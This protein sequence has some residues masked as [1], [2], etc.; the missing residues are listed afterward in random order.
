[1]MDLTENL[2]R[3]LAETVCGS[4]KIVYNGIEMDLSKPFERLTMVMQ[5]KNMQE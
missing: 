5:L 1:M 4:A 2:Y 3:H